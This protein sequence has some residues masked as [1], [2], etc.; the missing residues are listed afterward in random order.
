MVLWGMPMQIYGIR[1]RE[2]ISPVTAGL[3][4]LFD[5]WQFAG[6]NQKTQ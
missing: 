2:T 4:Q 1:A 6:M 3:I 5:S